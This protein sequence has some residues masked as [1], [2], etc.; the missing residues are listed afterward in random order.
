MTYQDSI[1]TT[2]TRWT[3]AQERTQRTTWLASVLGWLAAGVFVVP[4]AM[5]GNAVTSE[6]WRYAVMS[7]TAL[8]FVAPAVYVMWRKTAAQQSESH[9]FAVDLERQL[10]D[11]VASAERESEHRMT[12]VRRQEFETRLANALEMAEDEVEVIDAVERALG[13]T[14]P[15]RAAELLLADNSH[16]HLVRMA[17]AAPDNEPPACPVDSPNRCP[18][19][20][21]AQVQQFLDSDDIDSCPK[22]RDRPGGRCSAVCVPVSIMGRTV[23]VIHATGEPGVRIEETRVT[24]LSTLA[25]LAGSRIGLLRVMAETQLQAT[26]DSLTGLMNRRSFENK[27]RTVRSSTPV[28]LAMADLDHFKELNDKHGHETGDQ[29]LRLFAQVLRSELRSD[30]LVARYGGEEFALAM[31]SC[32]PTQ[33]RK[34]LDDLRD[35]LSQAIIRAGLPRFTASFGIAAADESEDL[36]TA[37]AQADAALFDAKRQGRDRVVVHDRDDRRNPRPSR[38]EK[39]DLSRRD[40]DQDQDENAEASTNG[41][42]ARNGHGPESRA[43]ALA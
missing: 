34:A 41:E 17:V 28:V 8:V 39:H 33:A 32:T 35:V 2:A 36:A 10:T 15:D 12:Q 6:P 24:D 22:L 25:K 38:Q 9:Q 43:R 29:S 23:G 14:L 4:I 3:A 5:F 19:A 16:A 40:E 27:V 7:A 37:L 21:R 1:D 20:R 42:P 11:A 18:A 30:D 31:P 26:T 13:T